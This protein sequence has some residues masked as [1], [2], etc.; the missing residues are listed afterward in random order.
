M[1]LGLAPVNLNRQLCWYS[2]STEF[3]PL[4]CKQVASLVHFF[5]LV[6]LLVS[7]LSALEIEEAIARG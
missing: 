7:I 4:A 5:I 2:Q 3:W 1:D 6:R